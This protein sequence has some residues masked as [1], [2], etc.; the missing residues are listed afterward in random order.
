[1]G[2]ALRQLACD[3]RECCGLATCAT[4]FR[5][6]G[7]PDAS[8]PWP[9]FLALYLGEETTMDEQVR[10]AAGGSTP[11]HALFYKFMSSERINVIT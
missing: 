8:V 6:G 10:S 5:R 9:A 11:V 4:P 1:M 3:Q 2:L 7:D